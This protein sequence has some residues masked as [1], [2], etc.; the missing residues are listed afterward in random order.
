M[1]HFGRSGCGGYPDRRGIAANVDAAGRSCYRDAIWPEFNA[2]SAHGYFK[3]RN[4]VCADKIFG[5]LRF[6]GAERDILRREGMPEHLAD[7]RVEV[8]H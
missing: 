5:H 4:G 3:N 6:G 8:F 2:F 1:T 7:Q